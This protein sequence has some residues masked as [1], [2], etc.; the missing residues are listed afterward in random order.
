MIEV[1]HLYKKFKKEYIF[2][3][4]S[5]SFA[6]RKVTSIIGPS[7]CGK[8]T[9][10]RM[11]AGLEPYEKGQISG[12]NQRSISYVFQE[13]RLLPWLNVFQNIELVLKSKFPPKE[14]K[15]KVQEV[16]AQ[17]DLSEAAE[18]MPDELSGGMQRRV[19]I[20]R[21]LAYDADIILLDEPFKGMDSKLKNE[22]LPQL[23]AVWE[24]AEKT[25]ILVTHDIADARELSD[26]VY[27][28]FGRPLKKVE[29]LAD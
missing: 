29:T 7:G 1:K 8:T 22:V 10:L 23:A 12:I 27:E 24:K 26:I 4:F 5:I 19:A 28:L 17:L 21:A 6:D 2:E 15:L 18:M 13:D 25:I 16:L 20:G 14:S 9:L 3:D 11:I